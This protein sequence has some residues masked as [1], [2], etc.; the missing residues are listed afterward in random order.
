[1]ISGTRNFQRHRDTQ[2][3]AGFNEGS[4]IITPVRFVEIHGKQITIIA[5]QQGIKANSMASR[6]VIKKGLIGQWQQLPLRAV[7][8]FGARLFTDTWT[9]FV[10]TGRCVAALASLAFPASGISVGAAPE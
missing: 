9:P 2:I 4:G 8:A 1:A 10:R 6:Q 3:T 5:C 7:P